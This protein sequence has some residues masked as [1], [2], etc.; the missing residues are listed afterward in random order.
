MSIAAAPLRDLV[1]TIFER[2]G[3]AADEAQIVADHLIEA[4]LMGHDSHGVIRVAPYIEL[5]R[6]GKWSANRHIEIVKDAGALVVVDGNQGI[7]QV[8]A[9]EA[10]DLGIERTRA[11]GVAVV[12]VRNSAHMGRIGAWAERAAAAGMVSLHFVNTTGFGIQVVGRNMTCPP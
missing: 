5:L 2:A 10:I 8:I 6:S 4:N 1:E 3:S 7:G 9:K 11:H 12:G